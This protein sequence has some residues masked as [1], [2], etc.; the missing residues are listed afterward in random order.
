MLR[1]QI[2]I[3]VAF[4]LVSGCGSPP[5]ESTEANVKVA[6]T[7]VLAD[8]ETGG[9]RV[10]F[11]EVEPASDASNVLITVQG[12]VAQGG[13]FLLPRLVSEQGPLTTL[14]E[15]YALAPD[16]VIPDE[17][18]VSLHATEAKLLGRPD[19][20]VRRVEFDADL[21]VPK[22]VATCRQSVEGIPEVQAILDPGQVWNWPGAQFGVEVGPC[23]NCISSQAPG[24]SQTATS[25]NARYSGVCN[26]GTGDLLAQA[27]TFTTERFPNIFDTRTLHGGHT[28]AAFWGTTSQPKNL[29]A[30]AFGN[31]ESAP[32]VASTALYPIH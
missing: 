14:E 16:S 12:V 2:L 13:D 17:V 8:F 28:Y 31:I 9:R 24:G 4:G 11:I 25:L 23:T 26:E 15:F 20:T 10:T 21:Q 30:Q 1:E 3:G 18:L 29:F 27:F 32:A 5:P 6:E 7:R 19:S 22:S